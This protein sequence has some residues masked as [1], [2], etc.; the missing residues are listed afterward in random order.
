MEG[1]GKMAK[2]QYQSKGP[3]GNLRRGVE[4]V[5]LRA[6]ASGPGK[7]NA[8]T[9]GSNVVLLCLAKIA[10]QRHAAHT[11]RGQDAATCSLA[12]SGSPRESSGH[13]FDYQMDCMAG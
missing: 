6:S 5:V 4:A 13:G 11:V 9:A 10:N 3:E 1:L 8:P 7:S 2:R 12:A